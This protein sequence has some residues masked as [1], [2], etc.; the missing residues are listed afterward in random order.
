[1]LQ[2]QK[3]E[4]ILKNILRDIYTNP[5]LQSS[6]AFKGG[7]C[8]YMFYDLDR[9]SVD[10]D[11]N[12]LAEKL[13]SNLLTEIIQKHLTITDSANKHSTWLW[14]G[15]YEKEVQKIKIEV[16]KRT[17]PDLYI[18]KDFYGLTIPIMEPSCMF[19]HKLC[20]ITDRPK[21]QNRDLYDAHFMFAHNFEIN[22]EII[23]L[24][25]NKNLQEYFA[26]LIEFIES[27]TNER[28]IL[29][30]LGELLT[31]TQK[32]RTRST[33]K[34]DILFDLKSLLLNLKSEK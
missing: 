14:V 30:G 5:H 8:L 10:L 19:A 34:R 20:A 15:S 32:D 7:T 25:T 11:F 23:K 2:I 18:N 12:L 22:E 21:L 1:M 6:L 27:H 31:D 29:D 26:V 9:F 24:R 3:H 16:S 33:L 28:N 17:Y 13:D 4:Q